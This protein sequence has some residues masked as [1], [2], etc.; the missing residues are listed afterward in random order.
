MEAKRGEGTY[1]A[2]GPSGPLQTEDRRGR[3][4]PPRLVRASPLGSKDQRVRASCRFGQDRRNRP[5]P[6]WGPGRCQSG[7]P[8]AGGKTWPGSG[9][10]RLH[11]RARNPTAP[12]AYFVMARVAESADAADLKFAIRKGVWVRVPSRV[13]ASP[14]RPLPRRLFQRS[15]TAARYDSSEPRQKSE[16]QRIS[17]QRTRVSEHP[18]ALGRID[19]ADG[20]AAGAARFVASPAAASSAW[21]RESDLP[22]LPELAHSGASDAGGGRKARVPVWHLGLRRPGRPPEAMPVARALPARHHPM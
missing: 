21:F 17:S 12:G 4:R 18:A 10:T 22:A 7:I 9:L 5:H 11:Q 13:P 15:Y 2:E 8:A 6:M 19:S 16:R 14:S 1:S 20:A 3:C